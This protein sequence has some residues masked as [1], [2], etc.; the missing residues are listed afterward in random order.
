MCECGPAEP[1]PDMIT[2]TNGNAA[3][4][5]H[6]GNVLCVMVVSG[7]SIFFSSVYIGSD[8]Y[9]QW[10]VNRLDV[11]TSGFSAPEHTNIYSFK[12]LINT[13]SSVKKQQ[14][15][16]RSSYSVSVVSVL[17]FSRCTTAPCRSM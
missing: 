5:T 8:A 7:P 6:T 11:P 14:L 15:R 1:L 9:F 17:T 10:L 2:S 16:L 12:F 3:S 13:F 4:T